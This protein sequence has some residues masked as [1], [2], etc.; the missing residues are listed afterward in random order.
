MLGAGCVCR[1]D[2]QSVRSSSVKFVSRL[3][4]VTM[5]VPI[6]R[7]VRVG[8][9]QSLQS[10]VSFRKFARPVLICL[11]WDGLFRP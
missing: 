9:G 7:E 6:F 3:V 11:K 5:S 2:S 10:V 8:C 4:S 1:L